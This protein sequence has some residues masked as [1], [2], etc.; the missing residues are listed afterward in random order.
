VGDA[1]SYVQEFVD[2]RKAEGKPVSG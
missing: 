1:I 2:K